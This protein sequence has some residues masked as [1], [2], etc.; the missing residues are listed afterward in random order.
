MIALVLA[1][2]ILAGAAA[3][4]V[5]P[6]RIL[7]CMLPITALIHSGLTAAFWFAP[8]APLLDG[9]LLLDSPGLLM[10]SITSVLFLVISVYAV[11]YLAREDWGHRRDFQEGLLFSNAR[12]SVFVGCLLVFLGMMTLVTISQHFGLLWVA[13]EATTLTS[14]PLIYFHRHV[15]SLEATWKYIMICSVGIALALLGNFFL[16][17]AATLHGHTHIPMLLTQ[18]VRHAS[19]LH[20][21]WLKATFIFMLVG[22]GTKMGLA[23]LHTWLPD[24]H[25]ESPSV[26]SAL[27]SGA[28]LNCAFLSILR[29]HQVILAAGM[30]PYG[31]SLLVGFGLL[32]ML[33]AAVFIVKQ[34]DFKRMLAYSSV[35]HMGIL[36]LGVGLGGDG[37][38]GAM[39]HALNHSLTKAML[40]LTAG[41][42]LARYHS[43]STTTIRG[44]LQTLPF[45]GLLWMG[46]FLAITG[47]PPF[48]LF[49]SELLILKEAIHQGR[50]GVAIL[51]L[52]ILG[53]I[54]MGMAAIFCRMA[55]GKP[56]GLPA[57]PSDMGS[58]T[59]NPIVFRRISEPIIAV[60]PPL[61]FGILTLILGVYI[62]EPLDHVL[63]KAA[64]TIGG[65]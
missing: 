56:G 11:G 61:A 2:P 25:S 31:Q 32:S 29:I 60:L 13:V 36:S 57:T 14:A 17:V 26:I 5:R 4:F 55:Q 28:L 10:L 38:Y 22:Y 34:L 21:P 53:V 24:A 52:G 15:R 3:F 33:I 47:S 44:V 27:L 9:W 64:A 49:V 18:L 37:I 62:P 8:A 63:G 65:L 12:E 23:P 54:F 1:I 7:R 41:N 19:E 51:Y 50:W 58:D 48:G 30:A 35:E 45:S 40:F 6:G 20:T 39:L 46:G 43:K 16:A 59:R 42:I